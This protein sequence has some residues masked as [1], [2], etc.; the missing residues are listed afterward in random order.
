MVVALIV[1]APTEDLQEDLLQDPHGLLKVPWDPLTILVEAV[2]HQ[3]RAEVPQNL[4]EVPR[5]SQAGYQ[6]SLGVR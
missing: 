1:Q 6:G 2:M 3:I 5:A 4:E